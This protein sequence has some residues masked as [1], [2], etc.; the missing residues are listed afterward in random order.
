MQCRVNREPLL[1]NPFESEGSID[2]VIAGA[3]KAIELDAK[4]APAYFSRSLANLVKGDNDRA[5]AD[6]NKAIE[7]DPKRAVAYF[8]RGAAYLAKGD[9]DRAI[10]DASKAIELDPKL[11][12]PTEI[13]G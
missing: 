9:N 4:M 3:T 13:A 2:R 1:W 8:S 11:A 7:L 10:A 6:T 5:I 12:E